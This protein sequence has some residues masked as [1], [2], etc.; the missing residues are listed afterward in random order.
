MVEDKSLVASMTGSFYWADWQGGA[1][2][3]G[4][5]EQ[6]LGAVATYNFDSI[7]LIRYSG[8]AG[9]WAI[10][11]GGHQ[12]GVRQLWRAQGLRFLLG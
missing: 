10:V 3:A 8:G 12:A 5:L 7:G 1:L 4:E 11:I 6:A 9:G 2:P